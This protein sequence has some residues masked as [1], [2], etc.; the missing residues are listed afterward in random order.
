VPPP[1]EFA[2]EVAA[3]NLE[4]APGLEDQMAVGIGSRCEWTRTRGLWKHPSHRT[5]RNGF[6]NVEPFVDSPNL[7]F[8]FGQASSGR[9]FTL[10]RI[11]L[12]NRQPLGMPSNSSHTKVAKWQPLTVRRPKGLDFRLPRAG[13]RLSIPNNY[14]I[15]RG[16]RVR[17]P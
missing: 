5:R 9:G 7:E 4:V 1:R 14:W 3:E 2:L 13:F 15:I 12:K 16:N 10:P 6:H 17:V 8:G 11:P